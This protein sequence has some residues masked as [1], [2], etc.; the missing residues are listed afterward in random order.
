MS[1][2]VR[3]SAFI[4]ED[5][6]GNE[7]AKLS[8]HP[9]TGNPTLVFSDAQGKRRLALAV[10][11]AATILIIDAEGVSRLVITETENEEQS[12]LSV[13]V[14]NASGETV[15]TFGTS[16]DTFTFLKLSP[17]AAKA[18]AEEMAKHNTQQKT[19]FWRR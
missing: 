11:D 18:V 12:G 4:V 6:Y 17:D 3:A 1:E 13:S 2:P 15:L 16:G 8:S 7:R 5:E 9:D 14:K 19:S 10:S